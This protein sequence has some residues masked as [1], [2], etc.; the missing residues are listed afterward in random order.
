M[1]GSHQCSETMIER[2]Y[3]PTLPLSPSPRAME[4]HHHHHHA[5]SPTLPK[6]G[7][8]HL[9][10]QSRP[11]TWLF[12]CSVP[13]PSSGRW[14]TPPAPHE[15]TIYLTYTPHMGSGPPISKAFRTPWLISWKIR[16]KKGG[17]SMDGWFAELQLVS[18][19]HTLIALSA[20]QREI[21]VDRRQ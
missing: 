16:E 8:W 2:P 21:C 3:P 9:E 10:Q 11:W 6:P 5:T 15:G 19:E 12:L 7:W 14:P 4:T 18:S 17:C 1:I 20:P 13:A